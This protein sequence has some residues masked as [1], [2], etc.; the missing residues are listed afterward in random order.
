MWE[1]KTNTISSSCMPQRLLWGHCRSFHFFY[2]L[3][4]SLGGFNIFSSSTCEMWQPKLRA[5]QY[6]TEQPT[7][8]KSPLHGKMTDRGKGIQGEQ[9][10]NFYQLRQMWM[11]PDWTERSWEHGV[12]SDIWNCPNQLTT[13]WIMAS[14]NAEV[15]LIFTQ[16]SVST[17]AVAL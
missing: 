11:Q 4:F 8:S 1:P 6:R 15:L 5:F 14:Q 7:V 13:P 10:I 12:K 3:F 9:H 16:K 17:L 2:L